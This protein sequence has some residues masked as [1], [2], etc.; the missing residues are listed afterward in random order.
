MNFLDN[1]GRIFKLPSYSEKPIGYEYNEN[2]Y[3]F[4]LESP[5]NYLSVNNYYVKVINFLIPIE[6]NIDLEIDKSININ[7]EI[8][9]DIFK[10]ISSKNINDIIDENL[11]I[12]EYVNLYDSDIK[13][14]LNNDDLYIIKTSDNGNK[15]L[16]VP[17]YVLGCCDVE[18]SWMTN[19]MIHVYENP[20][21]EQNL[22]LVDGEE[23]CPITIG[24]EFNNEYEEL[25][26]NGKN[27]GVSLPKDILKAVYEG[28]YYN[29]VFNETLY[30]E[31][32][33]E[34]LLNY[35][36]IN[37]SKGNYKSV[38]DSVNWFGYGNLISIS[39]L[40]QTDNQYKEQYIHDYFNINED[41]ID[42]FKKFKKTT[43]ISLK[44]EINKDTENN[45][46][47]D[48]NNDIYGENKP[49]LEDLTEKYVEEYSDKEIGLLKYV[50]PY[51]NY[52]FSE[53]GLKLS[54]MKYYLEQYFL[55]IHLSI[56]SMLFTH[57]VYANDIK[58]INKTNVSK[59]AP[60]IVLEKVEDDVVF[61]ETN[62]IYLSKQIHY[63]DDNFNEFKNI[64]TDLNLYYIEDT[65]AQIPIKFK[66]YDKY[67][68]CVLLLERYN[69]NDKSNLIIYNNKININNAL[70][71]YNTKYEKLNLDNIEFYYTLDKNTYSIGIKGYSNFIKN[72]KNIFKLKY[73]ISYDLNK[74]AY[75]VFINNKIYTL[76]NISQ[77]I[78]ENGY[79]III[80]SLYDIDI[81]AFDKSKVD[82]YI[83]KIP[84]FYICFK[85]DLNNIY[86]ILLND[87]NIYNDIS[88]TLSETSDLILEK[89]FSF[90]QNKTDLTTNYNAFVIY[91]QI[92][93][94]IIS[95]ND[96]YLYWVNSEFRIKL[97]VNNKW[98]TY[99]FRLVEPDLDINFGTLKY[100]YWDNELNY[101]SNFKQLKHI[102]ENKVEFNSF[103]HTPGLVEINNAT[104][105]NEYLLYAINN[106]I[107]YI[108]G[109]YIDNDEFYLYINLNGQKININR[110]L[111]GK[112]IKI[113]TSILTEENLY[114]F[115]YNNYIYI[116]EETGEHDNN[117]VL[118]NGGIFDTE[119]DYMLIYDG[120]SSEYKEYITLIYKESETGEKYYICY[121]DEYNYITCKLYEHL[122]R[123]T[124][125]IIDKFIETPNISD[126]LKYKNSI[127]LYDLYKKQETYTSKIHFPYNYI[128]SNKSNSLYIKYDY[129][130]DKFNIDG[131]HDNSKLY[132]VNKLSDVYVYYITPDNKY[133]T[134]QISV[135]EDYNNKINIGTATYK[136]IND[137]K[138]NNYIN[139][140]LVSGELEFN[141]S[142]ITWKNEL[143]KNYNVYFNVEYLKLNNGEYEKY[144]P[145]SDTFEEFYNIIK[146]ENSDQIYIIKVTYFTYEYKKVYNEEIIYEGEVPENNIID[147]NG[148]QVKLTK[149]KRY[150]NIIDNERP[151]DYLYEYINNEETKTYKINFESSSEN[152]SI[153]YIIKSK[154]E[155]KNKIN[156]LNNEYITLDKNDKIYFYLNIENNS[157]FNN[158]YFKFNL[159]TVTIDYEK[160]KYDISS[161]EE[162]KVD[163][164]INNHKYYYG[165]NTSKE[166]ISL[167]NDFFTNNEYTINNENINIITENIN[168]NS[169]IDYDMYLMHDY[170]YWYVIFISKNSISNDI[171]ENYSN[172]IDKEIFYSTTDTTNNDYK[173]IYNKSSNQ[174]LIN[175]MEL[176]K[177]NE[178]KHFNIDDII[179]MYLE[180]N[181]MIPVNVD[182][183]TKWEVTPISIGNKNTTISVS[184]A[185]YAIMSQP[186]LDYQYHKGYY[187]VN[188]QYTVDKMI[189]NKYN[190]KSKILIK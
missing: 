17:I 108:D 102:D 95:N 39:K 18:G 116:L 68:N 185:D 3:I 188:V 90:Y 20:N 66:E 12:K 70:T 106:N 45:Y 89:H 98:Y 180:N 145:K 56:H 142:N 168:I 122:N 52:S 179:V 69:L 31:K 131:N 132:F 85:Y 91:P 10:L 86:K 34:Y 28:S 155:N 63:V 16:I 148:E 184:N 9:S 177:K 175:R 53:L 21:N 117:Y 1:T 2:K 40:L 82:G 147:I 112:D 93:S 113:P 13:D 22:Y 104:F 150:L 47:F 156:L 37:M 101:I 87:K 170:E 144:I 32:L 126:K 35:F 143:N 48:F 161:Y 119:D 115:I 96:A 79:Y 58:F 6:G 11:N 7:I 105:I 51:Y 111:L 136:S 138:E 134:E 186:S 62:N 84:D 114:I 60:S 8:K 166:V 88:Y 181:D 130:N 78:Y 152:I 169:I 99:Q 27:M 76:T 171:V 133:T 29:D 120:E 94:N 23:W 135:I 182:K 163:I 49:I 43:Y 92:M 15:Y 118:I 44:L 26:I 41:I 33:R 123:N 74:D 73:V 103:M 30:N 100:K 107:K 153:S 137:F 128:L 160:L 124:N 140:D 57:K 61:P 158:D 151:L 81:N 110:Y 83:Y 157:V 190:K 14:I 189:Q 165:D 64:N 46:E 178:Y 149:T 71:I 72:L 172:D 5:T 4:W 65:C 162:N 129:V 173:L 146:N 80:P 75:S 125:Y 38:I 164:N 19:I 127:H 141:Q 154:S 167:Y 97:L 174:F 50:R 187:N 109:Q 159:S 55:P 121:Y 183:G 59:V 42:S 36:S 67:Y 77:S 54:I 24:G 139:I 25:T 176:L